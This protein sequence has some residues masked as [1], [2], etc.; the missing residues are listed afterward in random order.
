MKRLNVKYYFRIAFLIFS[1]LSWG[2][3]FCNTQTLIVVEGKRLEATIALDI[4]N[5]I[6]VTNDRITNIFGDEGTFVTQTDDQTGQVFIKPTAENGSKPLSLTIIT[7]NGVTQDLTLNPSDTAASTIVLKNLNS[8][9][10]KNSYSNF[11]SVLPTNPHAES[12]SSKE[13]FVQMMKQAVAGELTVYNKAVPARRSTSGYKT[14]YIKAYQSGPYLISV[15]SIK[16]TSKNVELH[17]RLF[18][19]PGDFAI[20]LQDRIVKNGKKTFAYV[21]TRL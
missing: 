17:E 2:L 13:Q 21:L 3:A 18:Y 14:N 12:I 8:T 6:A 4:M 10:S 9:Q 11:E 5:R 19:Q 16:N 15:W 7:E 1:S 20:C